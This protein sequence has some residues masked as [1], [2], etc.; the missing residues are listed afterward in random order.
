MIKSILSL[1]ILL[2]ALQS[3]AQ[4][5]ISG[6]VEN[7][8]NASQR[9]VS[10]T[11]AEPRTKI[12]YTQSDTLGNYSF[13][14][15]SGGEYLITFSAIGFNTQQK[16]IQLSRDTSINI[17]LEI[18]SN[19]L[20]DVQ[21][22]S[23]RPLLEKRI[24]RTIFNVENSVTAIG[25]DAL[26]LL[27]KVPGVRVVN[28]Q[29]S[30]VGKGGVNVMVNDK[31]IQL[32]QD[33]LS[34]YL[35]SISSHQ[36]SKIEV[37]TNPPAHYDAQG[38]NGLINIVLKKT[39][40][41]G[42]KGSV[43][44]VFT[45]ASHP[46]ASMGG[47]LNYRKDKITVNSTFNIRKGSIVPFEQ[48]TIFYPS[49]SWNVI[50][51]DRNFR[52][53]PSGQIG[54]DYQISKKTMLGAAYNGGYTNFH[55]EEN[56]KTRVTNVNQQLDSVLNSDANAVISSRY[57]SANLFLKQ[58]L[59]STG[60][61]LTINADW[62][63]FADD[64]NRTFNNRSFFGDG[65]IIPGSFAEYLSTSKQG[66]T[67]YTLKA[68]VDLPYKNFK[69]SFGT[70]LS[71]IKNESDIAFYRKRNDIYA[72][73]LS[74][75]NLFTY[76]ENTHALYANV[77]KTIKKWDFQFGLRSE[78]TQI[79]GNSVNQEIK[80]NYLQLFPTFYATYRGGNQ[81][82]WS[83]NYG[84][85]I[86]RPAYRKLNPFRWYSNQYVYTEGNPFLQ[87]SYNHNI[88]LSHTY[89]SSLTSTLSFSGA[90]NGFADVNFIDVN[91]NTQATKPVNFITGYS[92]QFINSLVSNP[93]ENWQTIN[94]FDVFYIVSKSAILQTQ[95]NLSRM[96]A[97]FST[98]NQFTIN[99]SKTVLADIN[100]W[101]QF[102]TAE[103]LNEVKSQYNL[104]FGVKTLL[105]NKKLQLS[106]SANDLLK[107]NRYRFSSLINN[108]KQDY[109]NYYDARQLRITARFNFGNEKLKQTDRKSGNEEERR[110]SN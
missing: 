72:V 59:D 37:I 79:N 43:N 55:S 101:F 11:L 67:L 98:S 78:Y 32:S 76:H 96:G 29:I 8:K 82:A 97:Y 99:K 74:Q 81:S 50:N 26:E 89:K 7:D 2:L 15:I 23:K 54:L 36:I 21:I 100:F 88:E 63:S 83:I 60:K 41:E 64:K 110:R 107:S 68:D 52:T 80:S 48:S 94:Q 51:K 77:N 13:S 102:P 62:F 66:I 69:V 73:D 42:F 91:S 57:H 86:N 18:A 95:A 75:S 10:I 47:N 90:N 5:R 20:A 34:N 19:E 106:L 45:Q 14:N 65:A 56:L 104:D 16:S 30:L 24:D 87:P 49:Q 35:K 93:F 105:L 1:L 44:T 109:N 103:G 39:T 9:N 58:T 3:K 70:K 28:D 108:I 25:S 22:N 33:D 61:Q 38:N 85:R 12:R 46:T 31:L 71:F 27:A 40:A 4:L 17:K 92:Y 53:V 84:R 6:K